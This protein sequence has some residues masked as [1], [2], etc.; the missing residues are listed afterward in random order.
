MRRRS[1]AEYNGRAA[2]A[3]AANQPDFDTLLS[4]VDRDDGAIPASRKYTSLIGMLGFFNSC[5][6]LSVTGRKRGSNN[7]RSAGLSAA[8]RRLR[9]AETAY[10]ALSL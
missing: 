10:M 9:G 7:Q 2:H 8:R 5:R 4:P 1:A 3:I 6:N